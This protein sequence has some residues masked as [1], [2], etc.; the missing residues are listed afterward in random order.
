M[1]MLPDHLFVSSCDGALHDTRDHD[2]P[3]HPLRNNYR[4]THVEIRTQADFKATLRNGAYAWP[5]GY[6]M[7]LICSD[8]APLCFA[9]G[10]KEARNILQ[11]IDRKDGSGWR[12][13]A[14][15]INHEDNELCCA[16]CDQQIESA[17]GED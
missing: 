12:V 3:A 4:R 2:W 17:C 1:T 13:L 10:H 11:S 6:P 7:Y 9:C 16:H 5:G 14:T 8:G 15:D